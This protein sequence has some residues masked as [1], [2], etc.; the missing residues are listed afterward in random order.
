MIGAFVTSGYEV[1]P[2]PRVQAVT[3]P[4]SGNVR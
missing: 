3:V 4:P 1:G 2:S